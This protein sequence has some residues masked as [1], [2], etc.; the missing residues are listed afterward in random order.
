MKK[1]LL[2][3]V[4]ILMFA[5][6]LPALDVGLRD[7][8]PKYGYVIPSQEDVTIPNQSQFSYEYVMP[9]FNYVITT[10]LEPVTVSD[11]YGFSAQLC[12]KSIS[13]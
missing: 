3:S 1:L 2:L 13:V 7:N 10:N 5:F 9:E 4:T 12:H 11:R 8:V 6:T